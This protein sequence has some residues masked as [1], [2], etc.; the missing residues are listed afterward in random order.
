MFL[1]NCLKE[2][3]FVEFL[4]NSLAKIALVAILAVW[5]SRAVSGIV[6]HAAELAILAACLQIK[7]SASSISN[8][9]AIL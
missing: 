8:N 4:A 7:Y 1:M 6:A 5:I 9:I 3:A 2:V